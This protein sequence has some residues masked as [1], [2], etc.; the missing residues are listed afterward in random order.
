METIMI[1]PTLLVWLGSLM[2]ALVGGIGS[3]GGH[4][5]LHMDKT[6][7]RMAETDAVFK[8]ETSLRLETLERHDRRNQDQAETLLNYLKRKNAEMEG[9]T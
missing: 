3:F 6:L 2:V 7:T 9:E 1:S 5:L 4:V 8:K